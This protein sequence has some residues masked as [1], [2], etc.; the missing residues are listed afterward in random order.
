[1]INELKNT[2]PSIDFGFGILQKNA[3]VGEQFTVWMST[4]YNPYK[5][6]E[7]SI[8]PIPGIRAV[9]AISRFEYNITYLVA[10][11]YE[12]SLNIVRKG[13]S[14]LISNVLILNIV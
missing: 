14:P 10:G 11:T 9:E 6:P 3:A 4:M 13:Q 7:A 12:L 1:M 8:P 5:G 2:P